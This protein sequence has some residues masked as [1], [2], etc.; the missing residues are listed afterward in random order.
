MFCLYAPPLVS[1]YLLMPS[2]TNQP[3]NADKPPC[4]FLCQAGG[5]VRCCG[6]GCC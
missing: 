2:R 3:T 6:G 4:S 5:R 1:P